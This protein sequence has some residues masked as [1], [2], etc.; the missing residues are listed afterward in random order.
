MKIIQAQHVASIEEII[1]TYKFLVLKSERKRPLG[2]TRRRYN[3][4]IMLR[5]FLKERDVGKISDSGQDPV[6]SPCEHRNETSG[7][8]KQWI[9][10]LLF[11]HL[12]AEEMCAMEPEVST[13]RNKTSSPLL[14]L[15]CFLILITQLVLSSHLRLDLLGCLFP[16]SSKPKRKVYILFLHM[17]DA[18]S[19]VLL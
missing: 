13:D 19:S 6:T 12:P 10:F 7:F 16:Q 2:G 9:F 17:C 8:I 14:F 1:K 4:R 5:L 11:V 3:R 18:L 15:S